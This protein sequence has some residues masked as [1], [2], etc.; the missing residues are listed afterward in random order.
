MGIPCCHYQQGPSRRDDENKRNPPSSRPGCTRGQT[1][2]GLGHRRH[3]RGRP[4]RRWT[5]STSRSSHSRA[6]RGPGRRGSQT[7]WREEAE[8]KTADS[9]HSCEK[10][11]R[12]GAIRP[13]RSTACRASAQTLHPFL[14]TTVLSCQTGCCVAALSRCA[15]GRSQRADALQQAGM[16]SLSSLD[17]LAGRGPAEK[18]TGGDGLRLVFVVSP[19][20]CFPSCISWVARTDH[21]CACSVPSPEENKQKEAG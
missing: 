10:A 3:R 19:G 4:G 1:H 13:T 11:A 21:G 20:C 17:M 7:S 6:C 14:V 2:R 9:V 15:G 12:R 18:Q 16:G 8:P 5:K